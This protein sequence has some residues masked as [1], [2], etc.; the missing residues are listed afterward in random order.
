M[1]RAAARRCGRTDGGIGCHADLLTV[2]RARGTRSHSQLLTGGVARF[3]SAFRPLAERVSDVCSLFAELG[4]AQPQWRC[5][6]STYTSRYLLL[7]RSTQL[8][9]GA[10]GMGTCNRHVDSIPQNWTE[11]T[12]VA[13]MCMRTRTDVVSRPSPVDERSA[14]AK[15]GPGAGR[16]RIIRCLR[17][18]Q[19]VS[20]ASA[21][22]CAGGRLQSA[23]RILH[24]VRWLTV[25]DW[26]RAR[27]VAK[28]FACIRPRKG[29]PRGPSCVPA[30]RASD[31]RQSWR[32]S[33]RPPP[34][35]CS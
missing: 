4:M 25:L 35:S 13:T 14:A 22:F 8:C 5:P 15:K 24:R 23:L 28:S 1:E 31:T 20:D 10:D 7:R 16:E 32:R 33:L 9:G 27:Q 29:R 26:W 3:H 34:A 21:W 18:R 17:C 11:W 2:G 6:H 12:F 30:V 19:R